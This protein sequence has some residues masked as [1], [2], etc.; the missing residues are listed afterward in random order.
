MLAQPDVLLVSLV[1]P[2][3]VGKSRLAIVV[4]L[5]VVGTGR[6]VAFAL[7]E[8]V[9]S[10]ERVISAIA[11]ALGVRDGGEGRLEEKVVAALDDR[12]LL[13][14]VDNMEHLLEASTVI[15]RL[16]EAVPRLTVLVT[17]RSPLHVRAERIFEVAP[18]E[19]PAAGADVARIGESPAVALFVARA[20]A[21]RPSLT[22]DE[23]N[24]E[25]IAA[26]CRAVDGVPLAIE[27]A[28]ARVRSLSPRQILERL[29]SALSLLSGGARDLP[30]RQ[31]GLRDTIEWSADLLETGGRVAL[32]ALSVFS[33]PFSFAAA[34]AVLLASGV[35]DPIGALESL[36]DSS[37]L[38]QEDRGGTSLF[39][40]LSVVRAYAAETA[41]PETAARARSAWIAHYEQVGR[42][43]AIRLRGS[44]QLECLEALELET[45]NLAA[46]GQTLIADGELDRAAEFAWSLYLYVWIGGYLEPVQAWMTQLLA[47]A[48]AQGRALLPRSRAI[49][50]YYRYA[51]GYWQDPDLDVLP[52]LREAVTRFADAGD[53]A[54]GA[55]TGFSVALALLSRPGV[56]DVAGAQSQLESSLAAYRGVHDAWGQAMVLVMLGRIDLL[57]GDPRSAASRF[58]ESFALASSAGERLGIV[59]AQN[60][61]GW[62]RFFAG[63]IPGAADDFGAGLDMSSALGHDEGIAYGLEGFVGVRA[64]QGD[65]TTAGLLLGAARALRRRKGMANPEAFEYYALPVQRLRDAGRGAELDEACARGERMSVEEVLPFVR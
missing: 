56:P 7:L 49:A 11:R 25:T 38:G 33:G 9:S 28:A 47:Q 14:V 53:P 24:A 29:D 23:E 30:A 5:F 48:E 55:L 31:R 26:I 64:A 17:S 10:P 18:L 21:A 16:I 58:D 36:L 45:E 43:A 57:T 4:A 60:H 1:G 35:D 12:D 40:L 34:E 41:A 51:I 62:A 50:L 27:L 8:S 6:D 54:S 61:R 59:I 32:G 20:A 65:V 63:D 44:D 39:Q 46:V 2:G 3:V 13:L 15:V 42:D 37:L 19:V 52:G 22:L